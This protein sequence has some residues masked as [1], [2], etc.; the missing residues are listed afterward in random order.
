M[1]PENRMN[2]NVERR[3]T[4]WLRIHEGLRQ[5]DAGWLLE[6]PA[7]ALETGRDPIAA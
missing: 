7:P 4:V 3:I 1:S 5:A 2:R 6:E